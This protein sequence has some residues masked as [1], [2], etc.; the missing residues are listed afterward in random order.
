[1]T[2]AQFV[3]SFDE[4]WGIVTF[5]VAALFVIVYGIGS[6]GYRTPFGRSLLV[7]DAGVSI[8]TLPG[9][10]FYVF[11]IDLNQNR[12]MAW[13]IV[14]AGSA[15]TLAIIYRTFTL[16]RVNYSRFWKSFKSQPIQE[17]QPE[18]TDSDTECTAGE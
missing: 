5:C 2:W 10:L 13:F 9:F 14:L 4:W 15:I 6:R 18:H 16:F 8:V 1:M 7:M 12:T 3:A 17:Q 11:N